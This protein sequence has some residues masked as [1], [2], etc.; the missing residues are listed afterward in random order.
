MDAG[1]AINPVDIFN[2]QQPVHLRRQLWE[3]EINQSHAS[4]E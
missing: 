2:R 4:A 1:Q 3:N